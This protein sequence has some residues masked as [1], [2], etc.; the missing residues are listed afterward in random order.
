MATKRLSLVLV[1]FFGFWMTSWGE[2]VPLNPSQGVTF[3][4]LSYPDVTGGLNTS[5]GMIEVDLNALRSRTGIVSGY[6][7]VATAAGWVVRNLPLPV[8]SGYPYSRIS[9]DFNLGVQ[10][11]TPVTQQLAALQ[12]DTS[13]VTT[14]TAVPGTTFPVVARAQSM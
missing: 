2:S 5:K 14:F 13:Q 9:A 4:Q 1:L 6:L 7:N 8:E 11:G 10:A 3:F 12:Y